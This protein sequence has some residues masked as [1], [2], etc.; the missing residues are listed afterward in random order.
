M[1]RW[2]KMV[3]C[4]VLFVVCVAGAIYCQATGTAGGWLLTVGAATA[5][6]VAV[7]E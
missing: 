2:Q 4:I 6:V 3:G 5:F 1:L 7:F